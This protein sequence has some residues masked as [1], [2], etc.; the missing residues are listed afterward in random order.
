MTNHAHLSLVVCGNGA[1]R[2]ANSYQE[3]KAR[4]IAACILEA[5][6]RCESIAF[7]ELPVLTAKMSEDAWRTV[8][9]QAGVAIPDDRA[10]L[11]TVAYLIEAAG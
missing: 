10:K 9:F 3:R 2:P 6:A 8:A 4:R 11:L 1:S 5:A 7:E